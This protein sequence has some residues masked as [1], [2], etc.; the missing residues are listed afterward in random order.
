MSVGDEAILVR[1]DQFG[2]ERV[3]PVS[4]AL[5]KKKIISE[6]SNEMGL[7]FAGS[8]KVF[9]GVVDIVACNISGGGS[10]EAKKL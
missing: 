2:K 6:F 8:S 7:K 4:Q 3:Y 10:W 5:R 9:P 1:G